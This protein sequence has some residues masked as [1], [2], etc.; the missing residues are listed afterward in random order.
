MDYNMYLFKIKINFNAI[1]I[2]ILVYYYTYLQ[3]IYLSAICIGTHMK[4]GSMPTH[5]LILNV[6]VHRLTVIY[7]I[8]IE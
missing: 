4:L 3:Q 7:F 2:G 6:P 5:L 1:L 8:S